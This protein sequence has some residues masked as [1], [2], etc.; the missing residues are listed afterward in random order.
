MPAVPPVE[1]SPFPVAGAAEEYLR[2]RR[3]L[4]VRLER[5]ERQLRR[6]D[7]WE[8]NAL[9]PEELQHV[10]SRPPV[11][12]TALDALQRMLTDEL[13]RLDGSP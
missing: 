13:A 8:T 11:P 6:W 4:L 7:A 10:R 9:L 3:R 5:V 12:R 2:R 1:P